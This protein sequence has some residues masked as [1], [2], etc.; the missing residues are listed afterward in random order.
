MKLPLATP[1]RARTL[2]IAL[3]I[4]FVLLVPMQLYFTLSRNGE[5]QDPLNVIDER[6]AV[7]NLL[8]AFA[9]LSPVMAG[10]IWLSCRR[11][12][13]TVSLWSLNR[14]RPVWTSVWTLLTLI[15]VGYYLN[16]TRVFLFGEPSY[17]LI[18][19]FW[20]VGVW[21]ALCVRA[22]IVMKRTKK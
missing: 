13:G 12:V 20:L 11:Y 7:I 18:S 9:I 10:I 4:W 1:R 19:S 21:L 8:I 5:D 22:S 17:P 16:W 2:G 3:A 15:I 14:A 6:V